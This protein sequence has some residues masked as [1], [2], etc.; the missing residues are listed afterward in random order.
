MISNKKKYTLDDIGD[1]LKKYDLD[2][3]SSFDGYDQNSIWNTALSD[4]DVNDGDWSKWY[5]S[6]GVTTDE[7]GSVFKGGYTSWTVYPAVAI[8]DLV[9]VRESDI[10]SVV[11]GIANNGMGETV[12]QIHEDDREMWVTRPQI[13]KVL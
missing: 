7:Y 2:L 12:Y 8:G 9:E 11:T 1:Y 10:M 3:K 6:M 5:G 4:W 13:R